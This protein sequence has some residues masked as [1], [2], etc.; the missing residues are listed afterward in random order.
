MRP[1]ACRLRALDAPA[2]ERALDAPAERA[3][4][5]PAG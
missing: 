5:A 3:L 4:D 2:A 1:D